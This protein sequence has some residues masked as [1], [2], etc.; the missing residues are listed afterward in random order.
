MNTHHFTATNSD[1][2]TFTFSRT[3]TTFDDQS[4][5]FDFARD[6]QANGWTFTFTGTTTN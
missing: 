3:F 1:G 2:R 5:F 4:R 6:A